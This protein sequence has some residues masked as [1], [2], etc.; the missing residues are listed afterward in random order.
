[1]AKRIPQVRITITTDLWYSAEFLHELAGQIDNYGT[2]CDRLETYH[3]IA[4]VEWP[5]EAY[6]EE[7]GE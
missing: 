3:G 4:K 6:E 5:D 7:E 2:D 1:M